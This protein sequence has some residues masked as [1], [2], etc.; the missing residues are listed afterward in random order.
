MVNAT[1]VFI[2]SFIVL[3]IISAFSKVI[4]N[5][6]L[7]ENDKSVNVLLIYLIV[8][9]LVTITGVGITYNIQPTTKNIRPP[10]GE[11]GRRGNRGKLGKDKKCGIKCQ[12]NACYLKIMAHITE[13]YNYWLKIKRRPLI[14]SRKHIA[15]IFLKR[16]VKEICLSD[17]FQNM[18]RLHG[19]HSDDKSCDKKSNCGAYDYIFR[20]WTEWILTILKYE[21]GQLF[22]DSENMNDNDFD[23]M[24]TQND[25]KKSDKV[26]TW[27]FPTVLE[28]RDIITESDEQKKKERKFYKSDI[29]KFYLFNGV[30][31]AQQDTEN[32]EITIKTPFEIIKEYDAW[33]WGANPLS[34]PRL[35]NNCQFGNYGE[36]F[37]EKIKIKLSNDYFEVWDS[38]EARQAKGT[39]TDINTEYQNTYKP[40]QQ[41]GDKHV[42]IYRAKDFYDNSEKNLNF[43]SYKPVGDVIVEKDE[44]KDTDFSL[45]KQFP[46]YLNKIYKSYPNKNETS[47]PGR[48]TIL[49]SGNVKHPTGYTSIYSR[50]R[51]EGF[52]ANNLAF[53]VWR[54]IPPSGYVSLGDII[55]NDPQ[56]KEP[57]TSLVVCVPESAVERIQQ[58]INV[59]TI[60]QDT[61]NSGNFQANNDDT[62]K[63]GDEL[64]FFYSNKK[65]EI[66]DI[67]GTFNE[68]KK[69][70]LA[71]IR[72]YLSLYNTFRCNS[73]NA[74]N[75]FYNI[76]FSSLYDD[77]IEEDISTENI[78]RKEKYGSKYSILKLYK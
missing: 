6:E 49:V 14:G 46:R 35:V 15:N 38:S 60:G 21:N 7:I 41:L 27:L 22:I 66:L 43:K 42:K 3:L 63:P 69:T 50:K 48:L 68:N 71:Q 45:N 65:D 36:E 20:V 59:Y 1:K 47:G 5:M 26:K 23:G 2:Y 8:V 30:P 76:N 57:D 78:K 54:P 64:Y 44:I 31:D 56:G 18:V 58:S 75:E 13:V 40:Y 9:S 32:T 72:P 29:V 12:D 77:S 4:F 33:Y 62:D 34:I 53:T 55:S 51:T 61:D 73:N 39:Y 16:K 74:Y 25:L 52:Q 19:S 67:K 70:N 24:I 11:K 37:K 28:I 17:E 10:M